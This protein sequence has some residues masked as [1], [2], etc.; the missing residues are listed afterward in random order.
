MDAVVS[1]VPEQALEELS[2]ALWRVRRLLELLLFRL[3]EERLL[4]RADS[5]RWLPGARREVDEVQDRLHLAELVRALGSEQVTAALGLGSPATLRELAAAAPEPW[6]HI[7][8]SHRE[9]LVA[10]VAAVRALSEANRRWA[11]DAPGGAPPQ[12]R[13]SPSL[14]DFLDDP[15]Q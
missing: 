5:A 14:V 12:V 13:V 9:A 11:E 4:A 8:G 15:L 10:S 7:L 2:T 6:G 1:R 3:E